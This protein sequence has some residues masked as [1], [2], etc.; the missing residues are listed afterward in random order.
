[1]HDAAIVL[2]AGTAVQRTFYMVSSL[3]IL[4]L[5][6]QP[7]DKEYQQNPVTAEK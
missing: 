7:T 3:A 4:P 1:M 5:G 2:A 6:L